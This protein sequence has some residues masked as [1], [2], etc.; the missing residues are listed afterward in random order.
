MLRLLALRS[1]S[2]E[3]SLTFQVPPLAATLSAPPFACT[4][5]VGALTPRNL[6]VPQRRRRWVLCWCG[7]TCS[8]GVRGKRQQNNYV[9]LVLPG[10]REFRPLAA[11][12]THVERRKLI[13]SP[14]HSL[15]NDT[16]GNQAAAIPLRNDKPGNKPHLHRPSPS[17][18]T[19]PKPHLHRPELRH[20]P[21]QRPQTAP[22]SP[23]APPFPSTTTRPKPYLHRSERRAFATLIAVDIVSS[24]STAPTRLQ[25]SWF[26]GRLADRS[27][28]LLAT[29]CSGSRGSRL[30]TKRRTSN[31]LPSGT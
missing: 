30:R 27:T 16:A 10:R 17:S 8:L 19:R 13:S 31:P 3:R 22:P 9:A 7:S 26:R 4:H 15:R 12:I 25:H 2:R 24:G 5:L 20:S 11:T 21:P 1:G 23:R 29:A 28:L 18:T 14:G 6:C